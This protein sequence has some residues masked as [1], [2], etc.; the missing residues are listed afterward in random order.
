VTGD[1]VSGVTLRENQVFL[2][3]E[4]ENASNNLWKILSITEHAD[5]EFAV[6]AVK[7]DPNKYT[8]IDGFAA[9]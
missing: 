8:D 2:T 3:T 1:T 7:H 9:A 6:T 5:G 4:D